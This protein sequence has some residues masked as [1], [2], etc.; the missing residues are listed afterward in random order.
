ME[1]SAIVALLASC[2]A[3]MHRTTPVVLKCRAVPRIVSTGRYSLTF[4]LLP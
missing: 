3:L 1:D 4:S 2:I